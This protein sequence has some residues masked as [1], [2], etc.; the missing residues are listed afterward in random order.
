[1]RP[2]VDEI[3]GS[4]YLFYTR[5]IGALGIGNRGR[6][7][8]AL[9][10]LREF[11][12][13]TELNGDRFWFPRVP[14]ALGWLHRELFDMD[15][16]LRWDTDGARIAGEMGCDEAAANSHVNLG[17]DYLVL[18]EPARAWEHLEEAGRIYQSDVWNRWRYNIRLQGERASYWIARGDLKQ[19]AACASACLERAKAT[20]SRKHWA[21]AH[22]LSGDIARLQDR[23]PDARSEYQQALSILQGHPCPT[24]EWK[25]LLA[26]ADAARRL[27]DTASADSFQGQARHVIQSLAESIT[28]T[29]LREGFLGAKAVRDIA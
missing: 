24:I 27:H 14:N 15:T 17:H 2:K 12:R 1:M 3:G 10:A 8:Q 23:L 6:I 4:F 16:A 20:R 22:K 28:E 21:W 26:A 7:S 29:A 9:S 11:Y 19:A 25:I 5:Y 18:G 13:L